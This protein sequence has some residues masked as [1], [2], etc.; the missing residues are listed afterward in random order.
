MLNRTVNDIQYHKTICGDIPGL[1][2][3]FSRPERVT[4]EEVSLYR[5]QAVCL[6]CK[7]KVRGFSFICQNCKALYCDKCVR[8]LIKIENM[9]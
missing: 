7:G 1:I 3:I 9:C 5:D 4:E 2:G 8:T 6:V